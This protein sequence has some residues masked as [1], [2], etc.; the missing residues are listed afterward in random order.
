MLFFYHDVATRCIQRDSPL[1]GRGIDL[2]LPTTQGAKNTTTDKEP[3]N[4]AEKRKP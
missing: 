2:K 3:A 1:W 4:A